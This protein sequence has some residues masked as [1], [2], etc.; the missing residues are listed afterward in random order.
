MQSYE[1]PGASGVRGRHVPQQPGV[2][3]GF[4]SFDAAA[5]PLTIL[6]QPQN[7]QLGKQDK[8][9]GQQNTRRVSSWFKVINTFY[10]KLKTRFPLINTKFKGK[11]MWIALAFSYPGTKKGSL[12]LRLFFLH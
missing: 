12:R 4:L 2:Q 10:K 6:T 7:V 3:V 5:N 8:A 11:K 1:F 9:G